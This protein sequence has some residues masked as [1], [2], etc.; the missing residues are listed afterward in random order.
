MKNKRDILLMI[1]QGDYEAF[2]EELS[3]IC[4]PEQQ[5]TPDNLMNGFIAQPAGFNIILFKARL[6][7]FAGACFIQRQ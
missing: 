6:K 5:V 2:Y 3:K 1:A 4:T 7:I